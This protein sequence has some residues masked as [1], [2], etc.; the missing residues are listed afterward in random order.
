MSEALPERLARE[1]AYR[2]GFTG[3][4]ETV[5]TETFTAEIRRAVNAALDEAAA[6]GGEA[7]ATA[8]RTDCEDGEALRARVATAIEALKG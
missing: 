6:A 2:Q 7:A 1:A 4:Y 3:R 8:S 5:S